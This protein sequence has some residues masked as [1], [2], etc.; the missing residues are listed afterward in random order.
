ML[1][2]IATGCGKKEETPA[3]EVSVQAA[4]VQQ[5]PIAQVITA[6]AVLTPLAQAAISPKITAPVRKFYVQ[7]GA[8][9]KKGQ[10]LATL[11]NQDLS[12]AVAEN[13][14]GYDSAEATYQTTTQAQVPEDYQKAELDFV[15]A[16]ANLDLNRQIANSRKQLFQQGAISG[17]DLDTANAALVQA[18]AAYDTANKHFEEMKKVGRNAALQSAHGQLESARGKYLGA[19]A[20]LQYSEIRSPIAGVVTDRPL[21]AGETAAAGA[22]LITVMDLSALIAKV[23]LSETQAQLVHAGDKASVTLNG[24]AEPVEGKVSL[25]SPAVDPGSTTVEIWVRVQNP[26]DKLRPGTPVQISLQGKTVPNALVVPKEALL[27]TSAG[28][29]AV[30]VIGA[31]SIA[32]Q[33]QVQTGIEQEGK[34]QIVSGVAAGQQ[35]VTQGAYALDDGTKVKVSSGED[36]GDD[37]GGS[38]GAGGGA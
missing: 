2:L 24:V 7:R 6:D 10:L 32:H 20:Q 4:T 13:K 12:A 25:V 8:K 21:F 16:K 33:K 35:V 1:A 9:V 30:M 37:K 19:E 27:T 26:K 29:H 34:V 18:Q 17:H 14:G 38:E 3:V 11:E 28:T 22:P 23:H 31:D 5:A 15:Q 36:K